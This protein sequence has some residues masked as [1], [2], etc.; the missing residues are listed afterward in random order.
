MHDDGV[1]RALPDLLT[2]ARAL[3]RDRATPD[4]A[5]QRLAPLRAQHGSLAIDLVWDD[6]PPDSAVH[7]DLLLRQ[8]GDDGTVSLSFSPD[9][10][11]P[12]PLRGAQRVSDRDLVRVDGMTLHVAD[13]V[14]VLEMLWREV[15]LLERI[16]DTAII[17]RTLQRDP[18]DLDAADAQAAV[19]AFRTAQGLLTAAAT[20][21]WLRDRGLAP[22]QLAEIA[23]DALLFRKL[24]HRTVGAA[25]DERFRASAA[26]FDR[27]DLVWFE[28]SSETAARE[29]ARA[30]AGG[31]RDFFAAA[32][33]T[34]AQRGRGAISYGSE[35][36]DQLTATDPLVPGATVALR[37][38]ARPF[39][40]A[41]VRAIHPAVLDE[42]T[43]DALETALF[44]EWLATERRRARVEW[45]WGPAKA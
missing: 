11:L 12:F 43:R 5:L 3:A 10:A 6:G 29:L 34:L 17:R 40:V 21:T 14:V 30:I 1:T 16:V 4:E 9:D 2:F 7:Y 8:Q 39:G 42:A 27:V 35:L 18:I 26:S 31:D 36:R 37:V 25:V 38:G 23:C 32:D 44:D 24:R 22:D 41:R 28:A 45:N 33:E 19:D 20:E 13:A 15:R